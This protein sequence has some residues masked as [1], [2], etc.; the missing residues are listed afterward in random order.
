MSTSSLSLTFE[1]HFA[2]QFGTHP[3]G[4]HDDFGVGELVAITQEGTASP[5]HSRVHGTCSI[6]T[7]P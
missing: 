7:R 4:I 1:G 5:H 6:R 2:G 3:V